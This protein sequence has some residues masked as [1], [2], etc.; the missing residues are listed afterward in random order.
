MKVQKA[1]NQ[2]IYDMGT[3]EEYQGA[4]SQE[5][6]VIIGRLKEE[7]VQAQ[8]ALTQSREEM[9]TRAEHQKVVKL[10]KD[11]LVTESETYVDLTRA[12]EKIKKMQSQFE[13]DLEQIK[14]IC[15][16]YSDAIN[17]RARTTNYTLF[18]LEHYLFL[19][20]NSIR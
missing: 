11:I 17:C 20:V 3:L 15:D 19:R 5:Q 10:L 6:D 12:Q 9:I 18:L 13:K 4:Q 2:S 8:Q 16:V 14:E 1:L 7:L